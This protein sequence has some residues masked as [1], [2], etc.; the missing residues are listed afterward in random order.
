MRTEP[1]V[2]LLGLAALAGCALPPVPPKA[3]ELGIDVRTSTK[4]VVPA[5]GEEIDWN[6]LMERIAHADVVLL[7]ELHDH[8]VGHAVE[9]AVVEDVL[10]RWPGSALAMEMLE[11]DEQ[12]LVEDWLDGIVDA[13]KFAKLTFSASWAGPGSW[14]SWYQPILDAARDRGGH[15]IAANAPRRYVHL[16][17]TKGYGP[18]DALPEDRRG[19]ADHPAELSGGRYRER[20]WELAVHGGGKS[21]AREPGHDKEKPAGETAPAKEA[22][23]TKLDP[24]DPM[25]PMFRGQQTWD[26]TMAE[27]VARAN[28]SADK[29]VIL[30]VGDFHVEYDGGIV[31]ELRKRDPGVRILVVSIRREIPEDEEW[32]GD[33]PIADVL[34]TGEAHEIPDSRNRKRGGA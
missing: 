8:A 5:S 14:A 9:L 31:Q 15:I 2:F 27:S 28:P 1:V 20:F 18:L 22:A 16:A 11:R 25:L 19:L 26:A 3:S 21:K 17:S 24:N 32:R 12:G 13:D 34:V 7:G 23:S 33:P 29:K 6:G 30:M 10:D 4:L